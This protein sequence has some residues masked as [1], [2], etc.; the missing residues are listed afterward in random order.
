MQDKFTRPCTCVF[1]EKFA[2]QHICFVD[3]KEEADNACA[4]KQSN[5]NSSN[6][7]SSKTTAVLNLFLIP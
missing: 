5:F 1:I 6:K 2:R 7:D 3:R 4:V